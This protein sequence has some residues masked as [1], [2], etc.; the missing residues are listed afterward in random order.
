LQIAY[1]VYYYYAGKNIEEF[2]QWRK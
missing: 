1:A 2:L